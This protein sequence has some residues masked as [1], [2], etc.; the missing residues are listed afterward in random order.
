MLGRQPISPAVKSLSL[1]TFSYAL[2]LHAQHT[3]Q[4]PSLRAMESF[5]SF[6]E[7]VKLP[8]R[9]G[10]AAMGNQSSLHVSC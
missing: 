2:R 4:S 3:Y 9:A 10:N 7:Q 5:E 1:V 8:S 6:P